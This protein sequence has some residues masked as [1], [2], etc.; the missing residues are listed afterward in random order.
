MAKRDKRIR[1]ETVALYAGGT[2]LSVWLLADQV[3]QGAALAAG[4]ALAIVAMRAML[5]EALQVSARQRDN[6]FTQYECLKQLYLALAPVQPLPTTRGYRGSPDFLLELYRRIA[7][8]RPR[9]IVEASSG[10]STLVCGYALKQHGG[11]QVISL[12]HE[13]AFAA[14]AQEDVERHGL[15]D[16]ARVCHA[17]LVPHEI[18]GRRWLWYDF[19]RAGLPAEI[20]MLVVDG[21]PSG[22]QKKARYP[23]V[24]LLMDRLKVGGV[25]LLDDAARSGERRAAEDWAAQFPNLAIERLPLEKGLV[26]ATK[27][28]PD[29]GG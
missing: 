28:R 17:P 13:A 27:L 9:V 15:G 14:A 19:A 29:R 20:D 16:V 8:H 2:G 11:G 5:D 18:G 4:F 3:S 6:L 23:A 22:T 24:P 25:V 10:L 7:R 21:P 1:T 26:V 12:E